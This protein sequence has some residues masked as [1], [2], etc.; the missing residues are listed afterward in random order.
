M[1]KPLPQRK[2]AVRTDRT[3]PPR[4]DATER[5]ALETVEDENLRRVLGEILRHS[6]GTQENFETIEGWFP[7]QPRDSV[8][9]A[10]EGGGVE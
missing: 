8:A 1:S 6:E 4:L 7:I 2:L 5:K 10:Y 3:G 9:P